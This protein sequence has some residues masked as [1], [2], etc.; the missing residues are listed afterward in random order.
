VTRL[1]DI[2]LDSE[3]DARVAEMTV[4][5]DADIAAAE[6]VRVNFRWGRAQVDTLRRAAAIYGVPYQTYLKIVALRAAQHDLEHA[7]NG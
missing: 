7:A 1:E 6:E 4:Q 3:T 5:A 2:E